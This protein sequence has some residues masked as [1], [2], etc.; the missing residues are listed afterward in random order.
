MLTG[1]KIGE[2]GKR[3]ISISHLF[4]VDDL[5]TYASDEKGA[6][7]WLDVISQFTRDTSM[8]LGSDKCTCLNIEKG[9]QKSLGNFLTLEETKLAELTEGECYIFFN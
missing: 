1:Y 5:K 4:F 2:S 8:Q 3:S 9:N 6:T 7:L